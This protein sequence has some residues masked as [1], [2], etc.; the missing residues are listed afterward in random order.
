MNHQRQPNSMKST[1]CSL[2]VKTTLLIVSLIF[3]FGS[4]TYGQARDRNV[5]SPGPV[6]PGSLNC[7]T[8]LAQGYL[9][10]Y[11]VT[12]EFSDGAAWYFPRS[13]FVIY[14][15]DGK[16]FKDVKSQR[17]ADD[18]IPEVVAL[19][20]GT[21]TVVARSK[22]DGYVRILVVIKEGQQTILDLDLGEK[23]IVQRL[24]HN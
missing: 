15:I 11:L 8:G 4:S 2:F 20:V 19:P 3:Y 18:E 22:R 9:K 23:E 21:Y 24:V 6:R 17:F 5:L 16:L 10:V 12:D 1:L 7:R 13:S 14:R